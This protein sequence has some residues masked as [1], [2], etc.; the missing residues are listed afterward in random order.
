VQAQHR[1]LGGG[2]AQSRRLS[3]GTDV[4]AVSVIELGPKRSDKLKRQFEPAVNA[5][6]D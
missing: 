4:L 1:L 6:I 2:Q 3:M 5:A